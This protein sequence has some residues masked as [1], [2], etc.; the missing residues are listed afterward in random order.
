MCPHVSQPMKAG[1]FVASW[2][3]RMAYRVQISASAEQRFY[4]LPHDVYIRV[5]Q[6]LN[7][8]AH[9]AAQM[10]DEVEP[11]PKDP[12]QQIDVSGHR[13]ICEVDASERTVTVRAVERLGALEP[14]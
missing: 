11:A 3:R 5:R 9:A 7:T 6:K 12:S 2:A 4:G 1:L 10:F 8:L 14:S 13:V